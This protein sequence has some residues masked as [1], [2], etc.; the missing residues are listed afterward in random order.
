ME[1]RR[2]RKLFILAG[3]AIFAFGLMTYVVSPESPACACHDGD[4]TVIHME[5][6]QSLLN[7]ATLLGPAITV[8]GKFI[9]QRESRRSYRH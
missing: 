5:K 3:I 2:V 8:V 1:V 4:T 9:P 6:E 7:P